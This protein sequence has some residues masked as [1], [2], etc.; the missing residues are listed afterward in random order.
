MHSVG[1]ALVFATQFEDAE[2]RITEPFKPTQCSDSSLLEGALGSLTTA[3]ASR[4]QRSYSRPRT[5]TE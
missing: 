4:I 2:L 3:L 5:S 1:T